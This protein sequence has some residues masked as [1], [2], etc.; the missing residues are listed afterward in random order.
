M[1]LKD[2]ELDQ[3]ASSVIQNAKKIIEDFGDRDP[4]SKGEKE[5]I[6]YLQ[7]E[8]ETVVDRTDLQ[9]FPV[10]PKLFMGVGIYSMIC[11]LAAILF[12][13]FIPWLGFLFSLLGLLIYLLV[14]WFYSLL[15]DYVLLPKFSRNLMGIK[16]PKKEVQKRIV[17]HGHIDASYE[18]RWNLKGHKVYIGLVLAAISFV[19]I[20]FIISLLNLIFNT[21]WEVGY[22]STWA[23]IG[24]ILTALSPIS[25]PIFFFYN[26][27]V[28]SP[29]ANDNLSGTLVVLEVAKICKEM[30]WELEST[31]I[32]YLITGSE[33]AGTR[34]AKHFAKQN[35]EMLSSVE[36]IFI[37]LDVLADADKITSITTDHNGMVKLDKGVLELISQAANERNIKIR[38]LPF[39]PGAGSTD[40]ARFQK[41]GFP[42][43]SILAVDKQLPNWYHT[44]LDTV[45]NMD[46]ECIKKII[47]LILATFELHDRD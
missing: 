6:V 27:K 34:G 21:S 3:H 37:S 40:A 22:Q 2:T 43:G 23:I 25:I 26:Y 16:T 28:V 32:I 42:A 20:T 1:K 41:A 36:T 10:I 38:Q 45:E 39:P 9:E 24:I 47:D 5:A 31:E 7:K 4:G 18:M 8:F 46:K 33:E 15:L 11:D 35:K 17:I 30:K 13:W 44:R 12:Y 19:F 29:G 14:G